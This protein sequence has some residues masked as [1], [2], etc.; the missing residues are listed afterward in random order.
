MRERDV[1]HFADPSRSADRGGVGRDKIS[2]GRRGTSFPLGSRTQITSTVSFVGSVNDEVVT[3]SAND[4]SFLA[5]DK[6]EHARP[7]LERA[8]RGRWTVA[9]QWPLVRLARVTRGAPLLQALER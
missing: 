3:G 4:L 5:R 7:G 8:I 9:A 1:D 6:I 2:S